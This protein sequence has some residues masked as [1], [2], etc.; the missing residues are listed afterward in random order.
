MIMIL[1]K[2]AQAVP[3]HWVASAEPVSPSPGTSAG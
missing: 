2:G 3:F 1:R